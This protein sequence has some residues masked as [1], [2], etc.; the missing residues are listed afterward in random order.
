MCKEINIEIPT[1]KKKTIP[2]K[3]DD[4]KNQY[5]FETKYD[6]LRVLVFY[7][8]LDTLCQG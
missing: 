4:N 8:T 5:L 1:V 6:E 7:Y 3:L 2:R